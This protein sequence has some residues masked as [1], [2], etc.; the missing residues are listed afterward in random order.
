VAGGIQAAGPGIGRPRRGAA[1]AS[2]ARIQPVIALPRAALV[3]APVPADTPRHRA[4]LGWPGVPPLSMDSACSAIF[5]AGSLPVS[6]RWIGC[7]RGS[8]GRPPGHLV[9]T[10]LVTASRWLTQNSLTFERFIRPC[11]QPS[12][13]WTADQ[14]SARPLGG[15]SIGDASHV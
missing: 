4:H 14:T 9:P 10:V 11:L 12:A 7:L 2:P 3:P 13:S 8:H 1:T 6:E 5:N 15:A